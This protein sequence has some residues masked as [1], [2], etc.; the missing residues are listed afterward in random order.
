LPG[1]TTER[2]ARLYRLS[3]S[4]VIEFRGSFRLMANEGD[5]LRP[6]GKGTWYDRCGELANTEHNKPKCDVC[7]RGGNCGLDCTVSR[8]TCPRCGATA[9]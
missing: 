4:T 2:L 3:V 8:L 5:R 9:E 1:R 6:G 7:A